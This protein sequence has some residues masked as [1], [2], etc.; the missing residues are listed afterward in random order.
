M[1]STLSESVLRSLAFI[2]VHSFVDRLDIEEACETLGERCAR[3]TIRAD[4]F[5]GIATRELE[6]TKP[7]GEKQPP[8]LFGT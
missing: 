3:L 8:I 5:L 1:S 6:K 7:G 2:H 4:V